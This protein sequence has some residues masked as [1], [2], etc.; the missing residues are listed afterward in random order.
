MQLETHDGRS[1]VPSCT[2]TTKSEPFA[3]NPQ[4]LSL[5]FRNESGFYLIHLFRRLAR[6][7]EATMALTIF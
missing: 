6:N 2:Y 7:L 4:L 3:W 5:P 1:G